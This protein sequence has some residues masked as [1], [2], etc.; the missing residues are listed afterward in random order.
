MESNPFSFICLYEVSG[1][2]L[3]DPTEKQEVF[4]WLVKALLTHNTIS[5]TEEKLETRR[6]SQAM[7]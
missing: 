5:D 4:K 6:F 1:W 2:I 7:R 3:Q